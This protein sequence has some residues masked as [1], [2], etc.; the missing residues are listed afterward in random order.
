MRSRRIGSDRK[1]RRTRK[2]RRPRATIGSTPVSPPVNTGGDPEPIECIRRRAANVFAIGTRP[3]LDEVANPT[4]RAM[5]NDDITMC[6]VGCDVHRVFARASV[7]GICRL[8]RHRLDAK[9]NGSAAAATTCVRTPMKSAVCGT[10]PPG[11]GGA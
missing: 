1:A 2:R 3:Q 7:A 6:G 8:G 9:A 11:V 4:M 10:D 5:S